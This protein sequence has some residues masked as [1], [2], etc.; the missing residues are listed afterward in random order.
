MAVE[1]SWDSAGAG[2]ARRANPANEPILLSAAAGRDG[3][4]EPQVQ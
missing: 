2:A 4:P 3:N 1:A